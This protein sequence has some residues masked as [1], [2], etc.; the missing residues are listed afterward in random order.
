MEIAFITIIIITI[1][2]IIIINNQSAVQGW[3]KVNT[4][5]VRRPHTHEINMSMGALRF[6]DTEKFYS[7]EAQMSAYELPEHRK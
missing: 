4:L 2:S 7:E 1:I 3:D 5:S 6:C